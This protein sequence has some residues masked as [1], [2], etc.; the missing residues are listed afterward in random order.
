MISNIK[1]GEHEKFTAK[2]EFSENEFLDISM[3]PK[4]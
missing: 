3:H 2:G 4:G 1:K